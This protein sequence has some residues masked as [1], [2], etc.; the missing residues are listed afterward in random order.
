MALTIQTWARVSV[1]A[2]EPIVSTTNG[3]F[4]NYNYYTADTQATVA[5]SG[6]F[7]AGVTGGGVAYDIVT[8]DYVAVYSTTDASLMTYRLTNTSGVITTSLVTGSVRATLSLTAAQFIAGYA[9]PIVALAAPGANRMYTDVS[10]QFALTYGSAQYTTGGALGFQYGNTANLA[11]TKVTSTIAAATVNGL[12]ASSVFALIPAAVTGTAIA[13]V[14]NQG[15]YLSNDTAAFAV[16][17]GSSWIIQ[18]NA[19]VVPTA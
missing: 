10:A 6:Y 7:N 19:R 11:G 8:G 17:T 1:S 4:R 9:T 13:S 3:C 2:N 16:G 5:A 12:A 18:V 15:I 14:V